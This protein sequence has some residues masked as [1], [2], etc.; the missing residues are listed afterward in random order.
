MLAG[1]EMTNP[2]TG[3]TSRHRRQIGPTGPIRKVLIIDDSPSLASV[4][5]QILDIEG[6]GTQVAY[7]GQI[8]YGTYLD[9]KPDLIIVDVYMTGQSGPE[10]MEQVRKHDPGI[11]TIYMSGYPYTIDELLSGK[12]ERHPASC[13]LQKPFS[14]HDLLRAIAAFSHHEKGA[15]GA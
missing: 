7:D 12:R 5:R 11:R 4:L 15:Q 3:L 8:G 2:L 13:F 9:F 10:L 14:R 1:K 6:Y